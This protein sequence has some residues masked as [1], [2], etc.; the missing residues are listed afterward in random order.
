MSYICSRTRDFTVPWN[1]FSVSIPRD[2]PESFP[3]IENVSDDFVSK[4]AKAKIEGEEGWFFGPVRKTNDLPDG[5]GVYTTS[6]WVHC[7]KV[8][9]G[10]FADGRRVSVNKKTKVLKFVNTK[11]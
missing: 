5:L 11:Y 9:D 4:R 10:L 8:K 2:L 3:K 7:G 1:I 6:A